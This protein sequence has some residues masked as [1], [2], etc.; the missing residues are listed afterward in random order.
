MNHA[1]HELF[2]EYGLHKRPTW[3]HSYESFLQA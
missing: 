1:E 3:T 2:P